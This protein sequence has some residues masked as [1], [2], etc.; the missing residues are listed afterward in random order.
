MI[1]PVTINTQR[2]IVSPINPSLKNNLCNVFIRG[3]QA[4]MH[5]IFV[6][7]TVKDSPI[8]TETII[9]NLFGLRFIIKIKIVNIK[10]FV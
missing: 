10:R 7:I 1:K 8:I 9:F 4:P 6:I 2:I 5:A 3:V